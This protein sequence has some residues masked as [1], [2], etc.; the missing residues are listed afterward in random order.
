MSLST[1]KMEDKIH[2]FTTGKPSKKRRILL[3]NING[4]KIT[5]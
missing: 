2:R 5:E 3:T 1:S 4:L